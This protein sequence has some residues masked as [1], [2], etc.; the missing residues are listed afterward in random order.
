MVLSVNQPHDLTG[1]VRINQ[2]Q[3]YPVI[4]TDGL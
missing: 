1:P 3:H 4:V 2:V